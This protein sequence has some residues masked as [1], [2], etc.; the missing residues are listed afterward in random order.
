MWQ[1]FWERKEKLVSPQ[2]VIAKCKMWVFSLCQT[3]EGKKGL[4]HIT[5]QSAQVLYF[6]WRK[7]LN[8]F[9][10]FF[11]SLVC[12]NRAFSCSAF[13]FTLLQHPLFPRHG[14]HLAFWAVRFPY[15]SICL[16]CSDLKNE[17]LLQEEYKVLEKQELCVKVCLLE[18]K[19]HCLSKGIDVV[20]EFLHRGYFL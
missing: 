15:L 19:V 4:R 11:P 9:F 20:L 16:C 17:K 1:V 6:L 3:W 5:R 7:G 10:L 2:F 12:Y 18:T 14:P 8:F 13:H